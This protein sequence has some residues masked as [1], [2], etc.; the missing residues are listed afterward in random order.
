MLLKWNNCVELPKDH[1]SYAQASHTLGRDIKH[2]LWFQE[3]TNTTFGL[4]FTWKD[5][6]TRESVLTNT[7][8][9]FRSDPY[10]GHPHQNTGSDFRVLSSKVGQ[11]TRRIKDGFISETV[12]ADPF[13]DSKILVVGAG[14][15]TNLVNWDSSDYDHV[16]SCNHFF[17]SEKLVNSKPS[18]VILCA[19]V[20]LLDEFLL[21]FLKENNST[22]VGFDQ[23]DTPVRAIKSAEFMNGYKNSFCMWLRFQAKLGVGTRLV[24]LACIL[25]AKEVHVVGIDGHS[26]KSGAGSDHDRHAF[27]KGKNSSATYEYQ[28]YMRL[29]C[30]FWDYVLN[31]I[32]KDVKFRNL[33]EGYPMNMSTDISRQM[34]SK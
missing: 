15:T 4:D 30:M 24:A 32:G 6:G 28:L 27:E 34:F 1:P 31:E 10:G 33:G 12:L 17:L 19:N 23:A 13:K 9:C 22:L 16:W 5:I 26:K 8:E 14:P 7:E 21:S 11:K 3:E 2:R 18:L 25:G 20:N 29:Y